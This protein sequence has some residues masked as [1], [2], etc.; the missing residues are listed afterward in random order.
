MKEKRPFS[1]K[2]LS[3]GGRDEQTACS[4]CEKR[5]YG[6]G[7]EPLAVSA[8][9]RRGVRRIF[10]ARDYG[11]GQFVEILQEPMRARHLLCSVSSLTL[12]YFYADSVQPAG[13]DN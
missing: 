1:K 9:H 6:T 10:V 5:N 11:P 4:I 8:L 7:K 3:S 12:L 13:K 2:P